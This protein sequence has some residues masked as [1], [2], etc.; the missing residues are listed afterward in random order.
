M[1]CEQVGEMMS[2]WL[3]GRLEGPRYAALRAHLTECG[4]CAAEMEALQAL[5][6]LLAAAPRVQAP[7]QFRAR[8]MARLERRT[9]VR[10]L[11]AGAAVLALGALALLLLTLVPLVVSLLGTS[12][13]WPALWRGGLQALDQGLA[14]TETAV[15]VLWLLV[16]NL[17]APLAALSTC[18]LALLLLLLDSP[19]LV[20]WGRARALR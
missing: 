14:L 1:Y 4:P 16:R 3:D 5:D 18:A 20:A 15:R 10:Q 2:E 6:R 11:A 8:V 13:L 7:P 17:A 12:S 19:H 9:Q